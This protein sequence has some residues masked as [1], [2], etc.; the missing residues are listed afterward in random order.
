MSDPDKIQRTHP[1]IE[2][3][4]EI[5]LAS[6]GNGWVPLQAAEA[7]RQLARRAGISTTGVR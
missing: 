1:T 4:I 3:V 7:F 5:Y 2:S 6:L